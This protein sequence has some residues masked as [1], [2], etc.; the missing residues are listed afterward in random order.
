MRYTEPKARSAELLRLALAHMGRHE[1][2][3]NPISFTVWYEYSAG[4]NP[5]LAEAIAG[6]LA[7]PTAIDD[8]TIL[9]LYQAHVAFRPT[10]RRS[11][12]SGTSCS[13]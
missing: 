10:A 7:K 9:K 4:T 13:G 1:A 5:P 2:S 12:A 8:P 6:L 3:F 11:T